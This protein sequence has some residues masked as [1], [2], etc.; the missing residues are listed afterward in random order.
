[1]KFW[2]HFFYGLH[3]RRFFAIWLL[4]LLVTAGAGW[5]FW[6]WRKTVDPPTN[7]QAD[8]DAEVAEA[9]EAA[10]KEVSQSPRSAAAWGKLGHVFVTHNYAE[11]AIICFSQA[12]DLHTK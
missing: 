9:I 10:R 3:R 5:H 6:P 11:Q 8:A 4:A 12:E 7:N 2:S 1:M